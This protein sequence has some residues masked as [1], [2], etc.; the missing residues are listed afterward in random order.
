M[1]QYQTNSLQPSKYLTQF[2]TIGSK[3]VLT[4]DS[5]NQ[6]QQETTMTNTH[7]EKRKTKIN[8]MGSPYMVKPPNITAFKP[9][10]AHGKEG[11]LMNTKHAT[12]TTEQEAI[13][14]EARVK[15]LQLEE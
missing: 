7:S 11:T 4:K 14:V 8:E 1:T 2:E 15:K 5:H 10:N 9:K 13:M 3:S 12:V 6:S